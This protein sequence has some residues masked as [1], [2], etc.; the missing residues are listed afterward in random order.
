[1]FGYLRSLGA[2]NAEAEDILQRVFVKVAS[3]TAGR[4]V[5]DWRPY[6]FRAARNEFYSWRRRLLR[7][8]EV[9]G[10]E[11]GAYLTAADGRLGAE[12]AAAVEEALGK[13]PA[14]QREAVVLKI[15]AGMTFREVAE[16]METSVSTAASRYNYALE[17]LREML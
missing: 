7:R 16:V 3:R 14:K 15:Y 17:K 12:E 4:T 1:M 2:G 10:A 9:G 6:L 11:E 13:L 8:R 5:K